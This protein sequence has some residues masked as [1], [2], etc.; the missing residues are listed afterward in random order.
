MNS[1]PPARHGA[2]AQAQAKA[3]GSCPL[4]VPVDKGPLPWLL[5]AGEQWP[6]PSCGAPPW[7]PLCAEPVPP[8]EA[9][10]RKERT[11]C[12]YTAEVQGGEAGP[13]GDVA[14]EQRFGVVKAASGLISVPD[15][16]CE[17]AVRGRAAGG[18][19]QRRLAVP[20]AHR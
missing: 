1:R 4:A 18:G 5:V 20:R 6:S 2:C 17:L 3:V 19:R 10:S 8:I 16:V 11:A 7:E 14:C 9:S 13:P 15:I 12:E